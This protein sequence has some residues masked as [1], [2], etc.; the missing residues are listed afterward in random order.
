M[1][2]FCIHDIATRQTSALRN[3]KALLQVRTWD[4]K[5]RPANEWIQGSERKPRRQGKPAETQEAKLGSRECPCSRPWQNFIS[6]SSNRISIVAPF[7][8]LRVLAGRVPRD[9]PAAIPSRCPLD[10]AGSGVG[11]GTMVGL[12]RPRHFRLLA[13]RL[14]A[15]ERALGLAVDRKRLRDAPLPSHP[16]QR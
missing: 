2:W 9:R 10:S 6:L 3:G 8:D 1:Y 12:H 4:T 16:P 14:D 5:I 15:P 11:P 13:C 7:A